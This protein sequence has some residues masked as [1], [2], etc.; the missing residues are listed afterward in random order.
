VYTK[1]SLLKNLPC[2]APSVF[3]GEKR[4]F[5]V[6]ERKYCGQ[7]IRF[8]VFVETPARHLRDEGKGFSQ[9]RDSSYSLRAATQGWAY[10]RLLCA[11]YLFAQFK[12]G[13]GDHYEGNMVSGWRI[14]PALF[15]TEH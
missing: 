5:I 10:Y 13:H 3:P 2:G 7:E 1:S 12:P 14:V 15:R 6:I 9:N 11:N 4:V 8:F